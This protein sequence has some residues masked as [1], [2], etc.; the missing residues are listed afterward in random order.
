MKRPLLLAALALALAP[1][2]ASG[3]TYCPDGRWVE[4][5]PCQ[6]CPDGTYVAA[7]EV[8]V[9]APD[10]SYKPRNA[11]GMQEAPDGTYIPGGKLV[12]CPDGVTYVSGER[13]ELA[14]DGTWVGK[15]F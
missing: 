7:D 14:P 12:L 2:A 10:G 9:L 4:E 5:G 11:E 3:L 13:C 8:C 6:A 15:R 1:G